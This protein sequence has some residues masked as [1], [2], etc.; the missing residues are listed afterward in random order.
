[1]T[2]LDS[3]FAAGSSLLDPEATL[4]QRVTHDLAHQ[5]YSILDNPLSDEGLELL[6]ER[7]DQLSVQ[8]FKPAGIGRQNAYRLSSNTRRDRIHWLNGPDDFT[9]DYFR[10]I[11]ELRLAVNR[12]LFLGLFDYECHFAWYP[13]GGYYKKHVD[14]FR[15]ESNRRLSTIL[16]LNPDWLPGDGGELA[17]YRFEEEEEPF[18]LVQ[19]EFGR[20]VIFLSEEFLH[21]VLEA[22]K[23]RFSLSGWYRVNNSTSELPDP[24]VFRGV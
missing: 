6:R 12:E 22:H 14:A 21:E 7:V 3:R 19:P 24:P 16:Y 15:G 2:G 9:A 11:E 18:L 4:L 10:W 17:L 20:M 5:G 8:D 1:M 23:A 13:P